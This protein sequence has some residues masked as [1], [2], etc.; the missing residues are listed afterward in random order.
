MTADSCTMDLAAATKFFRAAY[1][2]VALCWKKLAKCSGF[3]MAARG[4]LRTA[5]VQ[6]LPESDIRLSPDTLSEYRRRFAAEGYLVFP[7]MVNPERL[8]A[9]SNDIFDAYEA[10]RSAGTL[11][12]GGGTVSGHLNCFPGAASRFVYD[13]LAAR[14]IF[15]LVEQLSDV[16]LRLPNVGCNLNLPGSHPQNEHVDGYAASPFLV[17]N[18]AAVDT[19]IENGAMEIIPGTHQLE[20]KYWEIA[21]RRDRRRV[22]LKQGDAL[23]RISTLWHRG[24]PNFTQRARPMLAFTWEDGGSHL[25]DPYAMHEGRITFLPNRYKT[26]WK[27]RVME[28]AFVIAPRVGT[29]Y[30]MARSLLE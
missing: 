2:N 26:D 24:M 28:R 6:T 25:S 23:L 12:V 8:Q 10:Q 30:R 9:L 17:V 19:T 13:T 29:A 14:G 7:N 20:Y 11:F 21:L 16:P 5:A 4:L 1:A 27:G 3:S 15:K 18:V 22:P